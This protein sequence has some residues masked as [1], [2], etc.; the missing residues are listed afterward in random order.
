[1]ERNLNPTNPSLEGVCTSSEWSG[2]VLSNTDTIEGNDSVV[3]EDAGIPPSVVQDNVR[4]VENSIVPID[5]VCINLVV[6][7]D[8]INWD[9]VI[10]CVSEDEVEVDIGRTG[11]NGCVGELVTIG[12]SEI[13]ERGI[14]SNGSWLNVEDVSCVEPRRRD[15][16]VSSSIN[17]DGDGET[18]STVDWAADLSLFGGFVRPLDSDGVVEGCV[19]TD[20]VSEGVSWDNGESERSSGISGW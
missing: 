9:E 20:F 15:G 14:G 17:V 4:V 19:S 16:V 13:S 7:I 3:L 6:N 10:C 2:F 18:V 11:G 12:I 8:D 1:L 5:S